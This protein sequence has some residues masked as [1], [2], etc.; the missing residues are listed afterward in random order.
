MKMKKFASALLAGF[1]IAG[2]IPFT[3]AATMAAENKSDF[4][5]DITASGDAVITEY[6]AKKQTEVEIPGSIDGHKITALGAYSFAY[7]E[8]LEKVTIPKSVKSIG[9]GAFMEC[10]N[11]KSVKIPDSVTSIRNS[12]FAYCYKLSDVSLPAKITSIED[13]VFSSTA[14]TKM[15]IPSTVK[16]INDYAFYECEKLE[17]ISIPD[18]VSTLGVSVFCRCKCLEKAKLSSNLDS[19]SDYLFNGDYS[20][21][22][23]SIPSR[24]K[25]IGKEAFAE[26]GIKTVS[27]SNKVKK[28][29]NKA[30][31]NCFDLKKINVKSKNKNYSS[32]NGVLYNK[33]QTN[34]IT[35]PAGKSS[36]KFTVGKKVRTI[37]NSAF[38]GNKKLETVTFKKGVKTIRAHAFEQCGIKKIKLPASV[39]TIGKNAFSSNANLKS[40]NIPTSVKE[41]GEKAFAENNALKTVKFKGSSKLKLGWGTFYGCRTLRTISMPKV[42]TSEGGL[43][44]ACT[45]LKTV[46]ISKNIKKIYRED[47]AECKKLNKITIPKTVK[48]IG[49]YAVGYINYYDYSYDKNDDLVI[50]G[51]KNS[52]AHKY[53]KKNGFTFKKIKK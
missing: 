5:Y 41:I 37:S 32:K 46:K 4:E 27:I 25:T 15:V 47:F 43:C 13:S 45:K 23:I 28:I 20:L 51:V 48:K 53:A 24:V 42:K 3:A 1:M 2:S 36:K 19:I 9:T 44:F 35:Y 30:F 14:I 29:E 16:I 8:K 22:S 40:V 49:K 52:A 50:K 26:S 10:D 11:L 39:K 17:S 12:A 7:L 31:F 18:S 34:I 38:Y 6:N 21:S 33:K